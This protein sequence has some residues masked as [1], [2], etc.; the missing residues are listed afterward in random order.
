MPALPMTFDPRDHLSVPFQELPTNISAREAALAY[1]ELGLP[2]FPCHPTKKPYVDKGF[3]DA[4]TDDAQI[5]AWWQEWPHA[6]IAM[7]MGPA[8][9][10]WAVDLDARRVNI[11]TGQVTPGGEESLRLLEK[12]FGPL[13]ETLSQRT[14]SGGRH[15]LF[16]WEGERVRSNASDIAP[17][18]DTRGVKPD[19]T[20]GG[21]IILAPSVH[22]DGRRYEWEQDFPNLGMAIAAPSWLLFFAT[23]NKRERDEL[24]FHGINGPEGFRDLCA[25]E[26]QTRLAALR[27]SRSP[28][29]GAA[30]RLKSR[31]YFQT[32]I[33]GEIGRVLRAI[34][35]E[36]NTQLNQSAFALGQLAFSADWPDHVLESELIRAA[37]ANGYIAR[38]GERQ[39]LATIRSGLTSGRASPRIP[40][41]QEYRYVPCVDEEQISQRSEASTHPA[42]LQPEEE[43]ALRAP[44]VPSQ[45]LF[46]QLIDYGLNAVEA[47]NEWFAFGVSA[48]LLSAMVARCWYAKIGPHSTHANIY[49][50][51]LASS[52]FGKTSYLNAYL[53]AVT[54]AGADHLIGSSAFGSAT[55]I[56]RLIALRG[57]TLCTIDEIGG[58]FGKILS[59]KAE[60]HNAQ[61]KDVLLTFFSVSPTMW[62]GTAYASEEPQV[63]YNPNLS[64]LGFSTPTD[65][66]KRFSEEQVRDGL[67]PR[68]LFI[69]AEDEPNFVDDPKYREPPEDLVDS[70]KNLIDARASIQ[71]KD[72]QN[73][74]ATGQG[75]Y[76]PI[77]ACV[78]NDDGVEDLRREAKRQERR[79][80]L[81]AE[82]G[83]ESIKV[84]FL[85]RRVEMATKLALLMAVGNSG[86]SPVITVG[87]LEHSLAIV[88]YLIG[89]AARKIAGDGVFQSEFGRQHREEMERTVRLL[90]KLSAAHG[91]VPEAKVV[92]RLRNDMRARDAQEIIKVLVDDGAVE[93]WKDGDR[94]MLK[95]RK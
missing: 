45:G 14:P 67:L 11:E 90:Q 80:V 75:I 41:A 8:S 69:A 35:G 54:L 58:E 86:S 71:K 85:G 12:Q 83:G 93:A 1:A 76:P 10:L 88:D 53:S 49:V 6:M 2:V 37:T 91:A 38:D 79:L 27:S 25:S 24:E 28:E 3:K 55:G 5:K 82:R 20:A 43:P 63:I 59:R 48:A 9:G 7:P 29:G 92:R 46:G 94:R 56:R 31:R 64:I 22:K 73:L 40:G 19:G 26:W 60:A 51:I 15:L 42:D 36:Q 39:A 68:F 16:R 81:E 52:A 47:P 4:T 34:P 89:T 33:D 72:I 70:L 65:F 84:P 21:Y 50:A 78:S 32:A 66:W 61:I 74:S 13:P 95:W 18:I 77:L 30:D 87:A 57:N 44:P 17:G 62:G 23:F